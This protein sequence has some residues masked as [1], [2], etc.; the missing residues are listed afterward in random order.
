MRSS[1]SLAAIDRHSGCPLCTIYHRLPWSGEGLSGV[2]DILLRRAAIPKP[3]PLRWPLAPFT[4]CAARAAAFVHQ[5]ALG[6]GEDQF[7]G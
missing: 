1:D 4:C 7:R 6:S 3:R 2:W 5:Y